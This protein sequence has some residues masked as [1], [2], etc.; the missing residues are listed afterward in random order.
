MP[1]NF[2]ANH[3]KDY[4]VVKTLKA[5]AAMSSLYFVT[6]V[7]KVLIHI[8]LQHPLQ[9]DASSVYATFDGTERNTKVLGN[10]FVF[11]AIGKH[12]K[13]LTVLAR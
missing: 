9:P 3:N 2:E 11:I 10:L 7:I 5:G 1:Y 12:C 13:G 6:K 4:S 8:I